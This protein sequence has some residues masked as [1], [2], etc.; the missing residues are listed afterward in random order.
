MTGHAVLTVAEV[1]ELMRCS[2]ATVRRAVAAGEL[3]AVRLMGVT[4]IPAVAVANLTL[5][6]DSDAARAD[7]SSGSAAAV[8]GPARGVAGSVLEH[9]EPGDVP[10]VPGG[11]GKSLP[12]TGHPTN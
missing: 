7:L 11:A 1:A 8:D 9:I 4:R 5:S 10:G 2:Q 12:A 3:P 6:H